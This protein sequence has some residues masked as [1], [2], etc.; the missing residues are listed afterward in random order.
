MLRSIFLFS[1]LFISSF[2]FARSPE[3][4]GGHSDLIIY[5]SPNDGDSYVPARTT[6][7]IRLDQFIMAGRTAADF[8][9]NVTGEFSGI[10][11]GK[12]I[13]SDDKRT[14]IFKPEQPFILNEKVNVIFSVS[15]LENISPVFYSFRISPMSDARQNYWLNVLR[16]KEKKEIQEFQSN[17]LDTLPS[18]FPVITIDAFNSAKTAPGNIFI[19]PNNNLGVTSDFIIISDNAGKPVF[20]RDMSPPNQANKL[21]VAVEDFKM[22]T[23]NMLSFFK[24]DTV[25]RG[26]IFIGA[27]LLLDSNFKVIDTFRCGNGYHADGH[28]FQ[29][30][31][32]GHALLIAY[33]P[34]DSV[35][36]REVTGDPNASKRATVFGAIIQELDKNK[37]VVF[38]WRSWDHFKITDANPHIRLANP[39]ER[40]FDY[41]HINSVEMDTDGMIIASFRHMDE[42]TK[43][44]TNN[45]KIIWRWGGGKPE[46]NYFKFVGDTL[47]FSQQHDVRRIANGHITLW[48]NGNYRKTVWADGSYHD[49]SYSRAVE[50]DLD[51]SSL[52]ANVVWE[53]TDLPFSSA[54]GNVQRLGNGNTLIGLGF[55]NTPNALELT[56]NGEKVFQMSLPPGTFNYRAFRFEF[57][58]QSSSVSSSGLIGDVRIQSIY[59]N[60]SSGNV[61]VTY[62][63]PESGK[64]YIAVLNILGQTVYQ[65]EVRSDKD[66]STA[67]LD[68]QNLPSGTYY[69]KLS[70]NGRSSFRIMV[71]SK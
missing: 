18:N 9:F 6:L 61:S 54:A 12:V 65:T 48:D 67:D 62:F 16:E 11:K 25:I 35:D 2:S 40:V 50:Y 7:L 23:N 43:I 64:T 36:M 69:C 41:A 55:L 32:N 45:G 46:N 4:K 37:D 53:F 15:A 56:P 8:V 51:E 44:N 47:P 57:P 34:D 68:L 3:V 19:A 5:R 39:N 49:T 71:V 63:A 28:D 21:P 38:Q 13:L 42:V 59:P 24:L 33:D 52:K 22:W 58:K 30:L 14:I 66:I 27:T 60:P 26:E 31:P 29:L 70:Q 10:H 1:I 20:Q 17:V